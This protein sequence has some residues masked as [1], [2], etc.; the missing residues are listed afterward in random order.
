M[1]KRQRLVRESRLELLRKAVQE[2]LGKQLEMPQAAGHE[3]EEMDELEE[4]LVALEAKQPK[5]ENGEED[6]TAAQQVESDHTTVSEG[7]GQGGGVCHIYLPEEHAAGIG[8]G[9]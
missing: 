4:K 2:R 6:G 1:I 8:S 9:G 5:E 3:E 7:N